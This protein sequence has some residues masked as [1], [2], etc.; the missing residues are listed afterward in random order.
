MS[1]I[2]QWLM[3]GRVT[4]ENEHVTPHEKRIIGWFIDILL[5]KG[6]T[7]PCKD[8]NVATCKRQKIFNDFMKRLFHFWSGKNL[9]PLAT[10][11][12][13]IG[14]TPEG[15]PKSDMKTRKLR[16]PKDVQSKE[17]L[18]R[19]LIAVTFNSKEG[20]MLYGGAVINECS[21][22]IVA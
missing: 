9:Q 10:H 14:F 20:D 22:G 21:R 16:I 17:E 13:T 5:D 2:H 8:I 6:I 7:F 11:V 12:Y 15:F 18:Y 19:K 3:S 4:L 1:D